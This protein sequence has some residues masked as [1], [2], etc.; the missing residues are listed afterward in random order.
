MGELRRIAVRTGRLRRSSDLLVSPAFVTAGCGRSFLW[1]WHEASPIVLLLET[2][3]RISFSIFPAPSNGD[4]SLLSTL[5][6][7]ETTETP[8]LGSSSG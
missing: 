4:H 2:P 7:E 8:R 5:P 3:F 6:P 1:Y